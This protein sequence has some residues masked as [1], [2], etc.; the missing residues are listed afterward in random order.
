MMHHA[1]AHGIRRRRVPRVAPAG[2]RLGFTLVELM[3]VVTI[4]GTLAAIA[5]PNF[6]R[7]RETAKV[8]RTATEMRSLVNGFVAYYAKHLRYPPDSHETLPPGMEEFINPAI[9]SEETPLGGHYNW[10]GPDQYPYAGLSIFEPTAADE[11]IVL[12]DRMLDDGD[13]AVGRFRTGENGRP[14][15]VIEE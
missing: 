14:T 1:V 8:A 13:L 11:L 15:L 5:T 4:I 12:L 10:E 3:I 9:W 6:M 2:S 7:Q